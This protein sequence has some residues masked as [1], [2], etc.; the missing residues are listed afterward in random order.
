MYCRL[1]FFEFILVVSVVIAFHFQCAL[2]VVFD[3]VLIIWHEPMLH[4]IDTTEET[5]LSKMGE[6]ASC[7]NGYIW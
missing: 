7:R 6:L 5:S 2:T 3:K 4:Y 1:T